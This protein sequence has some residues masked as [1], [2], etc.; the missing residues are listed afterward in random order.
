LGA[1]LNTIHNLFYYQELMQGLRA[2]IAAG[3][4]EVFVEDFW[5][6]RTEDSVA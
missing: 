6:R 1:R 2:A 3:Q 5:R 4:L